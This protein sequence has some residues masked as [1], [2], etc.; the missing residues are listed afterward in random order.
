MEQIFF[1]YVHL[2]Y[3]HSIGNLHYYMD[4]RATWL[5]KKSSWTSQRNRV[6]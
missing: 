1:L 4:S 5:E 2:V 3:D 6:V